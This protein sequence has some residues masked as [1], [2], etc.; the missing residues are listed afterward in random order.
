LFLNERKTDTCGDFLTR[1]SL[2][3]PFT[4]ID[5]KDRK[6]SNRD[7]KGGVTVAKEIELKDPLWADDA[8]PLEKHV[9]PEFPGR[10]P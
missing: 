5:Q 3:H 10:S 7:T 2:I 4:P 8:A 9:N 6:R 1:P